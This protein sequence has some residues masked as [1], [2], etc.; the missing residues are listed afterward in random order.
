MNPQANG[1]SEMLKRGFDFARRADRFA[2]ALPDS[3]SL[4]R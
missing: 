1:V 3:C 4:S 2:G